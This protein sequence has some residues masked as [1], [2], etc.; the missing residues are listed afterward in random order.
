VSYMMCTESVPQSI[1]AARRR[2]DGE[3]FRLAMREAEKHKWIE[4]EKLGATWAKRHCGT[5]L[6]ATGGAG[7]VI[8]GSNTSPRQVLERARSGRL[9]PPQAQ[10]PPECGSYRRNRRQ[11]KAGGENLNII[12]WAQDAQQDVNQVL[13]ILQMLDINSAASLLAHVKNSYI[14]PHASSLFHLLLAGFRDTFAASEHPC[15]ILAAVGSWHE[16]SDWHGHDQPAAHAA[17]G[18]HR[19]LLQRFV[20]PRRG[21]APANHGQP[22]NDAWD[23]RFHLEQQRRSGRLERT[24]PRD[25]HGPCRVPR[26]GVDK[27]EPKRRRSRARGSA[28]IRCRQRIRPAR[29]N[30]LVAYYEDTYQKSQAA[31][32]NQVFPGGYYK[33]IVSGAIEAFGWDML[34][35][36]AADKDGFERVLESSSSS[37][38]TTTKPGRDFNQ[39]V[40]VARDMSGRKAP[41]CTRISTGARSSRATRRCG[42]S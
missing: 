11:I 14:P 37:A 12:I 35:E 21:R 17:A 42:K 41:S 13:E 30:K 20:D 27:R 9:W 38:C 1:P 18:A 4:S 24:R 28:R 8:A 19:I 10:L 25:G 3:L 7:V 36:A 29:F 40:R 39:G 2:T 15:S 32:P 6:G 31:N 5:G 22:F 26:G 16:L 23:F 34:L 33:T